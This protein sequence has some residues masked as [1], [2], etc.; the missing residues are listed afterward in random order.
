[1]MS[2]A[3]MRAWLETKLRNY[4]PKIKGHNAYG[5]RKK[6]KTIHKDLDAIVQKL[7]DWIDEQ[8]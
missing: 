5:S 2:E 4:V 7:E 1:M 8:D 3:Q 6:M